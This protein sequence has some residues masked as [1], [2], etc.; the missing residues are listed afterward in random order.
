MRLVGE[1][2]RA[3]VEYYEHH[4]PA[5]LAY[6]RR[7]ADEE[8]A[9]DATAEAFL[10]A[11]RHFDKAQERGLP[12]L[13]R[14]TFN[15]IGNLR[16]SSHHQDKVAARIAAEGTSL[17]GSGDDVIAERDRVARAMSQLSPQDQEL[18][19]LTV[20]EDLDI[21]SAAKV[22]GC[23]RGTAYVRLHR[24]RRRLSVLL[25]TADTDLDTAST[26]VT[27]EGTAS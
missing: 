4:Y 2:Q 1:Q 3:F 10:A 14:A 15:A 27:T 21:G 7:R 22:V 17:I 11:W 20:W 6:A 26:G 19:R 5:V 16:R 12:W 25:S 8:T 9:R 24:A 18:L 23:S 13:Y